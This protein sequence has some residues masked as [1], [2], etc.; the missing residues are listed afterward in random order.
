ML[1]R[2]FRALKNVV[3]DGK[4][5]DGTGRGG[6]GWYACCAHCSSWMDSRLMGCWG[7]FG[8]TARI[9]TYTESKNVHSPE[10]SRVPLMECFDLESP[11]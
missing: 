11:G 9:S 5:R 6:T 1:P 8:K 7:F 3:L 4:G 10:I 2:S